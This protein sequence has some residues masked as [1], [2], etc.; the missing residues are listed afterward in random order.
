MRI[1]KSLVAA[2]LVASFGSVASADFVDDYSSEAYGNIG[3]QNGWELLP[4]YQPTTYN[5]TY[6]TSTYGYAGTDYIEVASGAEG[7]YAHSIG[8][9]NGDILEV[10]HDFAW[11]TGG[12]QSA[13]IVGDRASMTSNNK[14]KEIIVNEG[15]SGWTVVTNNGV[16][17]ADLGDVGQSGHWHSTKIILNF[18]A[19]TITVQTADINEGDWSYGTYNTVYSTS[20][21]AFLSTDDIM[22]GTYFYNASGG[23]NASAISYAIPEPATL[24]L[25]GLGALAMLRRKH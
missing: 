21:I 8:A 6:V 10:T 23:D 24:G 5:G 19:D 20:G 15:G 16:G 14:Q 17:S 2:A 3:G 12:A 9:L 7:T 18:A 4:T 1:V 11:V 22:I 13:L 25:M